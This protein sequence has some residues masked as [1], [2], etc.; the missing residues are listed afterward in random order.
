MLKLKS[1]TSI[2][3]LCQRETAT[4]N[5]LLFSFPFCTVLFNSFLSHSFHFCSVLFCFHFI[6]F[7]LSS[8]LCIFVDSLINKANFGD[9]QY[10][11]QVKAEIH[12]VL[13]IWQL[14]P[15]VVLVYYHITRVLRVDRTF[16]LFASTECKDT[17]FHKS[18]S[19]QMCS[20]SSQQRV[21]PKFSGYTSIVFVFY[22]A[23]NHKCS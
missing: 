13:S 16:P 9:V 15:F 3:Y 10:I 22:N 14:L 7:L 21:F 2:H 1:N 23:F 17:Y 19:L 4:I 8:T 18:K 11:T 12:F 20:R 5:S 6:S